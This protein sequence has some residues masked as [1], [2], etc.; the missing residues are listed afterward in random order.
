MQRD[1]SAWAQLGAH[2]ER[3]SADVGHLN[4]LIKRWHAWDEPA[5]TS[6]NV[7]V[8]CVV[9]ARIGDSVPGRPDRRPSALHARAVSHPRK[10]PTERHRSRSPIGLG[11]FRQSGWRNRPNARST[12]PLAGRGL[13][14]AGSRRSPQ[15][16]RRASR[17]PQA[18][19][20]ARSRRSPN[21]RR[22]STNSG[23]SC[24]S[25]S[26]PSIAMRT[27]SQPRSSSPVR[28]SQVCPS[29]GSMVPQ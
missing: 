11:R 3:N 17:G 27:A 2:S 20:A 18:C 4:G 10:L 16:L 1:T 13:S 14:D 15:E 24:T 8:H 9:R 21:A 12:Q 23:G 19:R 29:I 28:Y 26:T 7:A 5:R 25:K 22:C 6:L